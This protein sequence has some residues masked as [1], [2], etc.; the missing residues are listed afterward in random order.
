GNLKPVQSLA[1]A[2]YGLALDRMHVTDVL[3]QTETA[4]AQKAIE[5]A[6]TQD[7]AVDA[8]ISAYRAVRS[9]GAQQRLLAQFAKDGAAW[10]QV[11]DT[12]LFPAGLRNDDKT[13]NQVQAAS[14]DRLDAQM[15][16][17]LDQL[18]AS[19]TDAAKAAAEHANHT[20]RD[21]RDAVLILLVLGCVIA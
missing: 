7:A 18:S 8:A 2:R 12:K 14:A 13:F 21:A 9:D 10:K 6:K 11:R 19:E 15:V 5:A 1:D 16:S 17:D 4:A 20:Y 3:A